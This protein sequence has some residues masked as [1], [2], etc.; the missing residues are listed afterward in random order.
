MTMLETFATIPWP[1]LKGQRQRHQQRQQRIGIC[2][3]ARQI[4]HYCGIISSVGVG[5][6]HSGAGAGEYG[7]GVFGVVLVGPATARRR[8]KK[9]EKAE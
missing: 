4:G 7:A 6:H 3:T 5:G 1:Q 8:L 9:T 2:H